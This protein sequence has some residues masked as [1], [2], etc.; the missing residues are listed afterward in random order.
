MMTIAQILGVVAIIILCI[1]GL[2]FLMTIIALILSIRKLFRMY[3]KEAEKA[4]EADK[5][6]GKGNP[7][8]NSILGKMFNFEPCP[9][10]N[11]KEDKK[12]GKE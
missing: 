5:Y 4:T 6:P 2:I 10:C 12:D 7:L 3:G 9:S 1:F 11:D 8:N